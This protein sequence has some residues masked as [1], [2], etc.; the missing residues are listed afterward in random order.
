[1]P[2]R[3]GFTLIELL[4]VLVVIGILAAIALPKYSQMKDKSYI[5]TMQSDLRVLSVQQE[6]YHKTHMTYTNDLSVLPQFVTP[7]V[8]VDVGVAT[9]Q[10]WAATASH[11]GVP[12]RTCGVFGGNATP[13]DAPPATV[14]GVIAC[15]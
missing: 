7:G 6:L 15:N 13:A 14:S 12:G 10:S 1:M 11:A 4:V 8:T 3:S 9:P 2:N 5:A